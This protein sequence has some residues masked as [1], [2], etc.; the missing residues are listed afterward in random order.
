MSLRMAIECLSSVIAINILT[1][2]VTSFKFLVCIALDCR[3][4]IMG[5][6]VSSF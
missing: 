3:G 6:W 4:V 1:I 2:V 5:Y